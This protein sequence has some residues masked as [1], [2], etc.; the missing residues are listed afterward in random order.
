MDVRAYIESWVIPHR[1]GIM[2]T[3]IFHLLLMVVFLSVEI[4]KMTVHAEMEIVLETPDVKQ[5]EK[6]EKEELRKKVIR[7]K[8]KITSTATKLMQK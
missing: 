4:S 8:K 7:Q 3:L 6:R 1:R 2:G 5:V